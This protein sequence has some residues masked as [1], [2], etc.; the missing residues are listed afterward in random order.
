MLNLYT[1]IGLETKLLKQKTHVLKQ[2][3]LLLNVRAMHASWPKW[4]LAYDD[5][6]Q[7]LVALMQLNTPNTSQ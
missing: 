2:F 7:A 3:C 5:I 6:W 1:I 4:G